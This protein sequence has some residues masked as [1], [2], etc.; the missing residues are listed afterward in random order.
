[1]DAAGNVRAVISV[2]A[3]NVSTVPLRAA[4]VKDTPGLARGARAKRET[5]QVS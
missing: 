5:S 3:G 1:M 2:R 4:V